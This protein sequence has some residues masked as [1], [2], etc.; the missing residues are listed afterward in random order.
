MG[1]LRNVSARSRGKTVLVAQENARELADT[2]NTLRG[3]GYDVR[4]TLS[5]DQA[6]WLLSEHRP[7]LLVVDIGLGSDKGLQLIWARHHA[8]PGAPTIVTH[9]YDDPSR[10]LEACRLEAGYLKSPVRPAVLLR[11]VE[12]MIGS[13]RHTVEEKRTTPRIEL[14]ARVEAVMGEHHGAVIDVSDG[15]C[16]L[17]FSLGADAPLRQTHRLQIPTEK[18]DLDAS[19]VWKKPTYDG[20]LYGV[21]VSVAQHSWQ[22]WHGFVTSVERNGQSPRAIDRP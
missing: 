19:P 21:A 18:L 2:S 7:D 17:R 9:R 3:A 8:T 20:D 10:A 14:R 16:R 1:H 6:E 22:E 4:E 11:H 13:G 15:G 12:L 5:L